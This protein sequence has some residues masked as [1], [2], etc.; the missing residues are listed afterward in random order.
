MSLS[1]IQEMEIKFP[2][3]EPAYSTGAVSPIQSIQN[4]VPGANMEGEFWSRDAE[5][6]LQSKPVISPL[7][8]GV[9]TLLALL[10]QPQL[11]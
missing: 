1:L 8:S 6:F 4:P 11:C 9:G 7:C 5:T 10:R 2:R 3:G